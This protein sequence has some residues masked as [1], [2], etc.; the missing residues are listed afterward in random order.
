MKHLGNSHFCCLP[1]KMDKK[2]PPRIALGGLAKFISGWNAEHEILGNN[3]NATRLG[4]KKLDGVNL[5]RLT[6]N[7]NIRHDGCQ[8]LIVIEVLH[9]DGIPVGELGF[10][11][12]HL[13]IH[14]LRSAEIRESGA[15]NTL[16]ITN[17]LG[18]FVERIRFRNPL[19]SGENIHQIMQIDIGHL[20]ENLSFSVKR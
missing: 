15:E 4:T 17:S 11:S 12:R 5:V 13:L 1:M 2:R 14:R 9:L 16:K 6:Q 20:E 19:G 18:S 7:N 8:V 10:R 3:E